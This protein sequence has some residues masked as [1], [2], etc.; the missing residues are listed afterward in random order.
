MAVRS[1]VSIVV[2]RVAPVLLAADSLDVSMLDEHELAR[3]AKRSDPSAFLTAHVLLRSLLADHT[4]DPAGSFSFVRSCPTC[5]SDRH[6]KPMVDG[7]PDLHVSISYGARL[8][9]AAL[10]HDGPVGVDVEAISAADFEGFDRVT[11]SSDEIDDLRS[12]ALA[13]SDLLRARCRLWAR[14]EAILKATGH[15]LAID[16]TQVVVSP[17]WSEAA[18]VA[19]HAEV[20]RPEHLALSDVSVDD[21][22]AVAVALCSPGVLDVR[23]V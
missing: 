5:G 2:L 20:P 23:T 19:W 22:H 15:G 14:K 6:G 9:V 21:D 13:G 10:S 1:E 4:G 8:A 11:L 12:A 17:P 16:P 3:A 18:L 7:Q